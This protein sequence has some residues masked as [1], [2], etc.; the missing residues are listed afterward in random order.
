MILFR[1]FK[2]VDF[3]IFDHLISNVSAQTIKAKHI[4]FYYELKLKLEWLLLAIAISA[5]LR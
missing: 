4:I 5:Y 1:Y 3:F 2:F